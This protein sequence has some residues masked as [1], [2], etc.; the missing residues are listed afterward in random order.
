MLENL[1]AEIEKLCRKAEEDKTPA[2]A[3]IKDAVS[4][5]SQYCVEF[6]IDFM[7]I[8]ER[9][10]KKGDTRM[11]NTFWWDRMNA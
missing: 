1:T 11:V 2:H 9:S 10:R 5:L 3:F 4:I 7:D 8:L 6:D